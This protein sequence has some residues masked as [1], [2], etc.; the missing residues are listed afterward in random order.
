MH[1]YGTAIFWSMEITLSWYH[2]KILFYTKK[3]KKKKTILHLL[4]PYYI[5]FRVKVNYRIF[6]LCKITILLLVLKCL[7]NV[8]LSFEVNQASVIV[9]ITMLNSK[10]TIDNQGISRS[11]GS[12][13]MHAHNIIKFDKLLL[14][15]KFGIW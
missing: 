7:K 13:Q 4:T 14:L 11:F 8:H 5:I 12:I 6:Y 1:V 2:C 3:K 10:S 15:P 9:N